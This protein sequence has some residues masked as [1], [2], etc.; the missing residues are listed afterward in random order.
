MRATLEA[1]KKLVDDVYAKEPQKWRG[2][3]RMVLHPPASPS[4]IKGFFAS[5]V[6]NGIPEC[7][8][9][10]LRAS[11]GLEQGWH[12]LSFL[13][14][15]PVRQKPILAVIKYMQDDQLGRF[16]S[17]E[18]AP[19]DAKV[20]AWEA[21]SG[22]LFLANHPIVATSGEGDLLVYDIRP[23][24][25]GSKPELCWWPQPGAIQ[26]RYPDIAAYFGAVLQEVEQYHQKLKG[27]RRGKS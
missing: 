10:F 8:G 20:K 12:R 22:E 26:S 3:K 17:F 23:K 19:T 24:R 7:Y 13:G 25:K 4:A 16:K 6:G 21:K 27:A 1:I 15:A 14:T 9:E 18:G 11:D 2:V 5:A